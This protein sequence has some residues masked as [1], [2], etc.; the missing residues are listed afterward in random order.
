MTPKKAFLGTNPSP[1]ANALLYY[2]LERGHVA[3][4]ALFKEFGHIWHLARIHQRPDD[5]PIRGVPAN[6][7]DFS[8]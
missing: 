5:F 7:Q 3:A 4:D 2:W 1:S 6:E 8:G